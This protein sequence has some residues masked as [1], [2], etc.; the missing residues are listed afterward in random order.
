MFFFHYIITYK[1]FSF[2]SFMLFIQGQA[3]TGKSASVLKAVIRLT[4]VHQEENSILL[5]SMKKDQ[6][7]S[8]NIFALILYTLHC[9][10]SGQKFDE[11]VKTGPYKCAVISPPAHPP[12]PAVL[13]C[14]N[15]TLEYIGKSITKLSIS[16]PY[17]YLTLSAAPAPDLGAICRMNGCPVKRWNSRIRM[18][19]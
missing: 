16:P 13:V 4:A 18:L 1:W 17:S 6:R 2:L 5:Y 7:W 3:L 19:L 15:V 10:L 8:G 12:P 9:H 14:P 11:K